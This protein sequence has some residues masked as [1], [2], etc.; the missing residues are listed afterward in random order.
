MFLSLNLRGLFG[1]LQHLTATFEDR[2]LFNHQRRRLNVAIQFGRATEFNSIRSNDVSVDDAMDCRYGNF[3]IRINLSAGADDQGTAG[4]TDPTREAAINAQHRL[5]RSLARNDGAAT[6][7]TAQA[8]VFN[9]ASD[10]L[11]LG[12]SFRRRHP[13]GRAVSF[14]VLIRGIGAV[15]VISVSGLGRALIYFTHCEHN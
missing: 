4:R 9:F 5:E 7:E 14:V 8:A 2:A 11:A 1:S 3:D 6:D 15:R 12:Q 13:F 10:A